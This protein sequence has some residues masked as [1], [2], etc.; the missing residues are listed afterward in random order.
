[1]TNHPLLS[2]K[3]KSYFHKSLSSNFKQ[4]KAFGK[5][6]GGSEKAQVAFNE[7]AELT[8]VKLKLKKLDYQLAPKLQK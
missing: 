2:T 5:R 6:I 3:D 4:V 1:M 8:A 7:I